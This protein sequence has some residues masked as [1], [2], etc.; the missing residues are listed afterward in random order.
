M[1]QALPNLRIIAYLDDIV[2]QGE[3]DDET[4]GYGVI[5]QRK[6]EVGLEIQ[7]HESL[8][9]SPDFDQKDEMSFALGIPT[10][11]GGLVVAGCPV[12][13][14]E[15][16]ADSASGASQEVEKLVQTL[17]ELD[18]PVQ[19][20]LLLLRKS[21]QVKIV[22]LARSAPYELVAPALQRSEAAVRN[23]VLSLMGRQEADLDVEQL[24]LPI[25]MGG[26]GLQRLT[27]FEGVVC[28]AGYIAAASL[29]QKALEGVHQ[30]FMPLATGSDLI[31]TYRNEATA[32]GA[33]S[34]A[35]DIHSAHDLGSMKKLQRSAGNCAKGKL[36]T[37][38]IQKY[39]VQLDD[40]TTRVQAQEHLA[41][42]HGLQEGVGTGWLEVRSIKDQWEL[43]DATMKSALRFMLGV[44]PGPRQNSSY[45]CTCGHQG[46]DNHHAETCRQLQGL[47]TLCHDQ[48][49]FKVQFG[50]AAAGHSSSIEPQE[51]HLKNC[52]K[53]H[54]SLQTMA[55]LLQTHAN[56]SGPL[57][58]DAGQAT[59]KATQG[60]KLY[61]ST[62]MVHQAMALEYSI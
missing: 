53:L 37:Q 44:S 35:I 11:D 14:A 51:R 6:N 56:S 55:Q 8:V 15:F 27:G 40:D 57:T 3:L 43:D 36:H 42:L 18:L 34:E 59:T 38:P 22:H 10:A 54:A 60:I 1:Q 9:Y 62:R 17:M 4:E 61:H 29:T 25:C 48:I 39:K 47:W 45:T 21:L 50:A 26:L 30:S 20:K 23:A 12:G 5:K 46:S 16:I 41:R 32:F 58:N 52:L 33:M 2:L 24:Y 28:K 31:N 19:D 7:Q 13:E 49:Q